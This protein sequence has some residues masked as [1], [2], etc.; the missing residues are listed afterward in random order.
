M[1]EFRAGEPEEIEMTELATRVD[2]EEREM[3]SGSLLLGI[4][5]GGGAFS[6]LTARMAGDGSGTAVS[7]CWTPFKSVFKERAASVCGLE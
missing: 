7:A 4:S 2:V 3:T 5:D 1:T 6:F